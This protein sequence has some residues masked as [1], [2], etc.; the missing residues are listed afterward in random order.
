[1]MKRTI[2]YGSL[3]ML[4]LT[5]MVCCDKFVVKYNPDFEGK[6]RT[7][8]YYNEDF[9]D[10]TTSELIIEGKEGSY[11]YGCRTVCAPDLCDCVA[12]QGGKAVINKQHTQMKVG[13]TSAYPIPID[14]EP[15]QDANGVWKMELNGEEFIKQ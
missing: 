12:N 6:W 10:T 3:G 2:I 4:I 15:Y 9:L 14:V 8:T 7:A 13:S 1:M 11:K 5:V